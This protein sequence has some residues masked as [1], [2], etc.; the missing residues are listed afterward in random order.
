MD[1]ATA[2]SGQAPP[3]ARVRPPDVATAAVSGRLRRVLWGLA[4]ALLVG[5]NGGG[6]VPAAAEVATDEL[7][8]SVA[9]ADNDRGAARPNFTYA[10]SPGDVIADAFVVTNLGTGELPLTIYAADGY[11]TPQGHLDLRPADVVP[12]DLGSWVTL[13]TSEITLG[14]GESVEVPFTLRVPVDASPGDHPGGIVAAYTSAADGGTV[15]L[16]RRL[17]SRLHVRVAGEQNVGLEISNVQLSQDI[18]INPVTPVPTVLTYTVTNVGNVRTLAHE[19]VTLGGP[20]GSTVTGTVEEIMPGSTVERSVVLSGWPVI[21]VGVDLVL[22]P[23]AVDG[24]IGAEV[25]A[26]AGAWAIPW[27]WLAVLLLI[28]AGAVVIGVRR[29]RRERTR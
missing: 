25:G 23:E 12:A 26:T 20:G 7:T 22:T 9:P 28:V 1:S 14:A 24:A 11:T 21:R 13:D 4:L 18:A 2:R 19:S 3:T 15:R 16:D 8:W 17:G 10:V 6:Q 29:G 27:G 5:F